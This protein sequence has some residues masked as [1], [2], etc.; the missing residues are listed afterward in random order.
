[1]DL[2]QCAIDAGRDAYW[3]AANPYDGPGPTQTQLTAIYEAMSKAM[4]KESVTFNVVH[5]PRP[6][7]SNTV[8]VTGPIDFD[9]GWGTEHY[10]YNFILDTTQNV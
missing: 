7:D 10:A 1:M 9:P 4:E 2:P 5:Y 8:Y 6:P 3:D